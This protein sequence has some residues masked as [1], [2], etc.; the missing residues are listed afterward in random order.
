MR[1]AEGIL[2]TPF[3]LIERNNERTSGLEETASVPKAKLN[4]SNLT[5]S[6]QETVKNI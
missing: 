3:L 4:K 2:R 1:N 6:K 5:E